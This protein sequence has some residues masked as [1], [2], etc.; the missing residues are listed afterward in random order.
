M[1]TIVRRG[2]ADF[3][4]TAATMFRRHDFDRV[5]G[6]RGDLVFP[7]D[8]DLFGRV[9]AFGM[10]FGMPELVAAWRSSTFNLCSQSSSLSKLTEML[11]FHHRIG[12]EYPELVSIGD[13]AAGDLRLVRDGLERVSVRSRGL[14]SHVARPVS[15][16]RR[17]SR[18]TTVPQD[19]RSSTGRV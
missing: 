1:R 4:P 15:Q 6:F 11:R 13:V 2:P 9:C 18:I 10:F 17:A 5:G 3:G 8:M 12:R 14:V 19:S 7:M 16:R